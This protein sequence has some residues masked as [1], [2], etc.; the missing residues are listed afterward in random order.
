MIVYVA[1]EH[2]TYAMVFSF[3]V[4]FLCL[5]HS[6]TSVAGEQFLSAILNISK[7]SPVVLL[8]N[9]MKSPH[10]FTQPLV[11]GFLDWEKTW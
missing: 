1:S 11:F 4:C 9:W 3:I 2:K 8:L 5:L 6:Y 7:V 10:P